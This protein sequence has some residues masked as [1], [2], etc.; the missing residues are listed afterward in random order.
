MQSNLAFIIE[1]AESVEP[2]ALDAVALDEMLRLGTPAAAF[3]QAP[4]AARARRRPV[5]FRDNHSGLFRPFR[6]Y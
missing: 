5:V 2:A 4:R 1:P 6:I 3:G